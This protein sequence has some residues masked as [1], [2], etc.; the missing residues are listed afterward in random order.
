MLNKRIASILVT[1]MVMVS[2]VGC[3]NQV[4]TAEDNDIEITEE[5]EKVILKEA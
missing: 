1:S 4:N 5:I 3:G 2:M